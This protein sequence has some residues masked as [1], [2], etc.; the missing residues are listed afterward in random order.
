MTAKI[1]EF[2]IVKAAEKYGQDWEEFWSAY[3]AENML[4]Q[5][6]WWQ[7]VDKKE[8]AKKFIENKKKEKS[9]VA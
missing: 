6:R 3:E 9:Y 5:G 7:I 2:D 8:A 1:Y 4:V